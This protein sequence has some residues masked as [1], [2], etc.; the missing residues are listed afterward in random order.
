VNRSGG[1]GRGGSRSGSG[2]GGS[3]RERRRWDDEEPQVF[4]EM[5]RGYESSSSVAATRLVQ[6]WAATESGLM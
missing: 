4:D 3:R 2:R 1:R 6:R 5:V